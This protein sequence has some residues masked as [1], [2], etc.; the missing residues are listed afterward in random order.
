[1]TELRITLE[2]ETAKLG[3]VPAADVA[4]LLLSVEKAVAQAA[5][6]ALGRPKTTSG[7]YQGVIEQ[8]VRLQLVGV[9]E[10]SVVPVVALPVVDLPLDMEMLDMDV[11]T[12][13]ETALNMLLDAADQTAPKQSHPLVAKALVDVAEKVHV[14]DRYDAIVFDELHQG[15]PP[16]KVRLTAAD[17]TRLEKQVAESSVLA[18]RPEDVT[19][20]LFEA[21]FEKRT[22]K[23]RT[24][25]QGAVEV[26]FEPDHDDAIQ[27]ALRQSST[28]RGDVVYDPHTNTAKSVRL[29]E[30]V[31]GLEQLALEPG[32]FWRE[33]S[34]EQLAEE[35]RSGEPIDPAVLYDTDATDDEREAFIA[36]EAE[37]R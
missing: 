28:I 11:A 17:R 10:G 29:T 27:T 36:A 5:A 2:G 1:M 4:Q 35:Q 12:L 18:A 8:A 3:Q 22:A 30:M 19:G 32:E 33:L 37:L 14:G 34:F 7:R 26:A 13:G 9:E 23:L 16:R 25:T 20:V 15:R 31:L 21:D 24:P 6:V